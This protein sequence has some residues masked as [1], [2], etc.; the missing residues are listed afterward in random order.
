M[1]AAI[2]QGP[3]VRL[4]PVGM[5][6]LAL[7]RSVFIEVTVDGV[8][9][10]VV[11]ALAAATGAAGG[12]ERG[13]IAGFVLGV[14]YDMLEGLPIGSTAITM[15]LAGTVAGL[16]AV[17]VADPHWWLAMIFT[18][19]GA[20]VG[21]IMVPVVRLFTGVANPFEPRLTLVVPVVAVSAAALSPIFVPL[22]RWCLRIKRA[23]WVAPP[24]EAPL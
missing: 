8:I 20:A 9:I 6:L 23:E 1:L 12:S 16:L 3:L 19:L 21:E 13:A 22:G 11:L 15:T 18:A 4:V 10:Q 5:L 2:W 7:Q 14:M 24:R 17:I